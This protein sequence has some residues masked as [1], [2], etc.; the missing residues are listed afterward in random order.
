MTGSTTSWPDRLTDLVAEHGIVGA[1]LAV[2]H[3]GEIVVE[4]AAGVTN[5]ATGVEVTTDTLFQIGS[6]TK[7]WVATV[8]M[9]LVEE[10]VLDLDAP[11]VSVLPE[12]RLKTDELTAGVTIR[13]LLSHTSGIDGDLFVDTGRGD[14]CLEKY[15]ALLADA[16]VIHP[17]GATMSY[18]NAGY[19]LLGRVLEVVT[20]VQWDELMRERLF[21]PL[22]LTHTVTLPEEALLF[23]TAVGHDRQHDEPL[24]VVQRWGLMRSTGPAGLICSTPREVL[25]FAKLHLDGGTTAD[26]IK[27]L[28]PEHVTA[29]QRRQVGLPD[30]YRAT[31]WGLGWMLNEWDGTPVIGHDG[32]TIGQNAFL[33]ILPEHE[34]AICL[35]TNGGDVRAFRGAVFGEIAGALAGVTVKAPPT[36]ATEPPPFDPADFVGTYEKAGTRIEIVENEGALSAVFTPSGELAD[37]S[38]DP[39]TCEL[40]PLGP[41]AFV[42]RW[43]DES[44]WMS[45]TFY[46][47]P[48]GSRCLYYALRSV[49]KVG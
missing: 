1:S 15:V 31:G 24:K 12:V 28:L 23:R 30:Q 18:C 17:L 9:A 46:G 26:G 38:P 3:R 29:M 13:H 11:V 2:L 32:A 39:E 19:V 36:P 20:G 8:V 22:G 44:D 7:V 5:L 48:D 4:A 49:P 6:I 10:G 37:L 40:R 21:R 43:P 27:I 42:L 47:L 41:D 34:L 16:A 33:S 14:D 25:T 45:M 35:V